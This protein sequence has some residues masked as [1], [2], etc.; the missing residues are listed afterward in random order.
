MFCSAIMWQFF[1]PNILPQ[2]C[3]VGSELRVENIQQN[4]VIMENMKWNLFRIR[5][6]EML[7]VLTVIEDEPKV[8]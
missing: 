8:L 1:S 5:G 2:F 7:D 6:W 4:P 3:F